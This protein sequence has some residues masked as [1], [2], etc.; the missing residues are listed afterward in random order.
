[1][2]ARLRDPFDALLNMQQVLDRTPFSDWLGLP[3]ASR[4][5]FPPVNVFQQNDKL[6]TVCWCWIPSVASRALSRVSSVSSCCF[7]AIV[8]LS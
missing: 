6:R 8:W 5:A 3:T 7:T 2:V 1:M 4:G